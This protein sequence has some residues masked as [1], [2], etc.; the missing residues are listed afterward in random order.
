MIKSKARVLAAAVALVI[1]SAHAANI[2]V[3]CQ[4]PTQFDDQTLFPPGTKVTFNLYGAMQGQPLALLTPTPLATCL[5]V[6]AN[7]DVGTHVYAWTALVAGIE[8]L[9][10]VTVSTTVIAPPPI[11]P[12]T[13]PAAPSKPTAVVTP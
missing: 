9:Q 12:S 6:R 3:S 4:P 13:K 5:S 10:S 7:A 11:V 8:S 1:Q 2:T